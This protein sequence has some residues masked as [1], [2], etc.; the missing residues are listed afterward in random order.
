MS[1]NNKIIPQT[2]PKPFIF[3]LMPF[4][5]EF[6][7]VY[8]AGIKPACEKAGAYAERV[9]EQLYEGNILQR[10]YNQISKSDLII[11]DV[12]NKNPNVYYEVGYAHALGKTTILITKSADDIPFDLKHYYH[13]DYKD[14]I[15]KKLIPELEKQVRWHLE[16]P[17]KPSP[18]QHILLRIQNTYLNKDSEAEIPIQVDEGGA[19]Y[20]FKFV[21]ELNNS[22]ESIVR[23]FKGGIGIITSPKINRLTAAYSGVSCHIETHQ[24]DSNYILHQV[25]QDIKILPG[26]WRKIFFG[27]EFSKEFIEQ[28]TSF[29]DNEIVPMKVRLFHT[30]FG[31][32]DFS[33]KFIISIHQI[34]GP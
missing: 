25:S 13:I 21:L 29:K 7:D 34:D 22:V 24:L 3:V 16:N 11:A 20:Y 30:E 17:N 27:R 14:S 5:R 2:R 15:S 9:D 26:R 1:E 33:F 32:E 28:Q 19:Y 31:Y 6:D 4:A 8:E 23:D 12:T 18:S 10:I